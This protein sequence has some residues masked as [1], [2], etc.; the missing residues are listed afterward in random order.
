MSDYETAQ[1]RRN[2]IVG[3]FV[4]LAVLSLA[5]MIKKFGD[6]PT[7]VAKYNSFQ[8]FVQFPTAPGV[9][10]DTPVRFCGYQIGRVTK[11]MPPSIRPDVNTGL[12]YYQTVVIINI[13]KRFTS[14]P[15]NVDIKMMTRGLGS[16]YIELK[17]DPTLPL[18]RTD[19]NDPL[20]VYLRD[21]MW[22]QGS[23]GVASEF[24]TAETQRKLDQLVQGLVTLTQNAN[25]ILGDNE[26]KQN[27]KEILEHLSE[28]SDEATKTV[29][30]FR[31]FTSTAI[32]MSE[33]L[34]KT[35]VKAQQIIEKVNSGEGT[36]AQLVND[37]RLY[38]ETLEDIEQ[39]H[40]LLQDIKSFVA[41]YREKGIKIKL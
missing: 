29:K 5:W 16:S 18:T 2:T 35:L 6:V 13:D 11:V 38:E 22:I 19:P 40:L 34:S 20:S 9:Q 14:I 12:E 23:S 37:G 25:D 30:E 7:K 28:A 41:E 32:T 4:I 3:V 27:I 26:S 36:L 31:R 33:E 8:I 10:K 21:M 24:F 17:L 15:S 1:K 39:L